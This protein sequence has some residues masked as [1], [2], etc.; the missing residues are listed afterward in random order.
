MERITG[1]MTPRNRQATVALADE[2]DDVRP[3]TR[4]V[5]LTE[6]RGSTG[7]LPGHGEYNRS[8][9]TERSTGVIT[10]RTRQATVALADESDEDR[11]KD[12]LR[13]RGAIAE[14]VAPRGTAG[15]PPG[16]GEG[17][18][19]DLEGNGATLGREIREEESPTSLPDE[20]ATLIAFKMLPYAPLDAPPPDV[21]ECLRP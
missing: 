3:V 12:I 5:A 10:P 21:E 17:K 6:A 20:E 16:H 13:R 1:F 15:G 8:S 18:E 2:G 14:A 19:D 9:K 4:R 11:D 7:A